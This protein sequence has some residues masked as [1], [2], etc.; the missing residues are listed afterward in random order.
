[1]L[2]IINT[3]NVKGVSQA[4][5]LAKKAGKI[6]FGTDLVCENIRNR[7]TKYVLLVCDASE[8]T[9]KK[10]ENCCDYYGA[11]L[12]EINITKEDLGIAIGK[13]DTACVSINDTNFIKLLE[14][15]F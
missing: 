10:I 6:S 9:K 15:K 5:G 8:N 4:L 14:Q 12:I 3:E 13:Y 11:D 2:R 7:K 1:M